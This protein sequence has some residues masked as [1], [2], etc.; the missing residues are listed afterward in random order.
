MNSADEHLG[1]GWRFP[2]R[3]E[4]SAEG[5]GGIRT[6]Q[7]EEDVRE[8]IRILLETGL[9]ERVMRPDYGAG[10]DRYAFETASRQTCFRLASDVR[11]LLVRWEPR[12][13]VDAVNCH[14]D[15]VDG[16]IDVEIVYRVDPHRRPDNLVYPFYLEERTEGPG[17]SAA[18]EVP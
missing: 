17:V 1:R 14:P 12:V 16:R 7:G 3:W 15:S 9:G 2:V 10:I 6:V 5:G 11:R 4:W 8:A 18:G 13:I